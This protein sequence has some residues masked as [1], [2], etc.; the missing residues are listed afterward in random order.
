MAGGNSA[1]PQVQQGYRDFVTT[2][3]IRNYTN[4]GGRFNVN[5]GGRS[6]IPTSVDKWTGET[7]LD[8][9]WNR[10]MQGAM[11]MRGND[12]TGTGM[13]GFGAA[14]AMQID[15]ALFK[16]RQNAAMDRAWEMEQRQMEQDRE[17]R[18]QQQFSSN[19]QQRERDNAWEDEQRSWQRESWK[20]ARDMFGKFS[21][22]GTPGNTGGNFTVSGLK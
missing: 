13:T 22:G 5:A 10:A 2:S 3:A 14:N 6:V 18:E 8:P 20:R 15:N 4:S 7:R 16:Q 21:G 1:S 9:K 11:Q 17:G 19:M 12:L